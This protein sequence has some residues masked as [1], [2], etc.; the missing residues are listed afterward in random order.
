MNQSCGA[1]E[2]GDE[3]TF[4]AGL[5]AGSE[6]QR[7]PRST[8]ATSRGRALVVEPPGSEGDVSIASQL[9]EAGLEVRACAD[10]G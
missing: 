10:V 8:L 1:I 6:G 5:E 3:A 4:E 9:G 2:R 7:L